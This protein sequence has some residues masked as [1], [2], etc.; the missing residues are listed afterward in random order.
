M[1]AEVGRRHAA[2]DIL[3]LNAGINCNVPTRTHPDLPSCST[4]FGVNFVAQ[5]LLACLLRALR[6]RRRRARRR[7]L[8]GHAPHG[9]LAPLFSDEDDGG[10]VAAAARADGARGGGGDERASLAPAAPCEADYAES[11]LA[12]NLFAGEFERRCLGGGA[13]GARCVAVNPGA[14]DSEIWRHVRWPWNRLLEPVRAAFFL[15]PAEAAAPSIHAATQPLRRDAAYFSPYWHPPRGTP[16]RSA[17][18]WIGPFN[19]ACDSHARLPADERA[20]A[21]RL[22]A[23]CER[24]CDLRT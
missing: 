19:G 18:E 10:A 6:A 9:R 16:G 21:A 20:V 24:L 23:K 7:P 1:R 12:F 2:L 5:W 15:T 8:V 11:K 14:V 3:V 17:F 22:W 4:V 13:A